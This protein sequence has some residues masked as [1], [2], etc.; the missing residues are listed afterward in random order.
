[1]AA[2]K[3]VPE[4]FVI[5]PNGDH[6]TIHSLPAPGK[7]RWVPRRKAELVAAVRGGLLTLSQ[8]CERYSLTP[9]E[10]F[11]WQEDLQQRGLAGLR[12]TNPKRGGR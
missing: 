4:P 5:G 1:M 6:L 11:A 7:V 8:V 2:D 9:E 3:G 12:A 10:L